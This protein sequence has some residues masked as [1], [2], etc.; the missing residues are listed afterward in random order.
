MNILVTGKTG[1]VGQELFALQQQY[2]QHRFHFTGREQLDLTCSDSIRDHFSH[3]R[4]DLIINAAAYTAVDKAEAE[5]DTAEQINHRAVRQLAEIAAEQSTRL[6]HISTDYVFNG[7]Q[8]RPWQE[9][10]PTAPLGVYGA[11]KLRGEQAVIAAQGCSAIIR[12]GWVYSRFGNNFVKTMLKLG[13]TRDSLNVVDD[14]IGTP[15]HAAALA[16]VALEL[17][18]SPTMEGFSGELFHYSQQGVASWYDFACSIM[19]LAGLDCQVRPIPSKD[20]PTPAKRPAFSVLN[21]AK[22]S[23]QLSL[24]IPHWREELKRMLDK[25]HEHHEQ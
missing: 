10:D 19:E 11:T 20:Y 22:I 18:V 16:Q 1:Q 12:T 17:G 3:Q 8:H 4:Y 5:P 9:D 7:A 21:K 2:P 14:Q 23:T 15:T 25:M 6:V 24:H 13:A